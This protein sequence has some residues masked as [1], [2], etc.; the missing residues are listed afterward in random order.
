MKI[1][2]FLALGATALLA[3]T[4]A[5]AQPRPPALNPGLQNQAAQ[6]AQQSDVLYWY[7]LLPANIFGAF[8]NADR[9]DLLRSQGATYDKNRGFIEDALLENLD[10]LAYVER[11]CLKTSSWSQKTLKQSLSK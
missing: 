11:V 2:A 3:P 8:G 6:R 9:T 5:Q 7:N 4:L 1:P 10:L